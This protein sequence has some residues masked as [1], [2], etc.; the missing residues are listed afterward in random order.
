M[1]LFL[2]MAIIR[3]TYFYE[4]FVLNTVFTF[5]SYLKLPL[6]FLVLTLSLI[7]D[8]FT[9]TSLDMI[10]YLELIKKVN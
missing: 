1:L 3:T 6:V 4:G 10:K 2:I 5:K 9:H 7:L 8:I